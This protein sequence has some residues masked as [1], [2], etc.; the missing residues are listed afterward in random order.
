MYIRKRAACH[1]PDSR[2]LLFYSVI[3][4]GKTDTAA[5][6]WISKYDD[7]NSVA[8]RINLFRD[9]T[10]CRIFSPVNSTL[11]LPTGSCYK[12]PTF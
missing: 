12:D 10:S 1:P 8:S 4:G 11:Q 3:I 2:W 5:A 7:L 9:H 6:V